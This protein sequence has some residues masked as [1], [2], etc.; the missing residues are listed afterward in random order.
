MVAG[1]GGV[2]GPCRQRDASETPVAKT[3]EHLAGGRDGED[4]GAGPAVLE[5][6]PH[7]AAG[8]YGELLLA[9]VDDRRG[10]E[11]GR[12]R[13]VVNAAGLTEVGGER[14]RQRAWRGQ[15]RSEEV[16]GVG[17]E[18]PRSGPLEGDQ[19]QE[20]LGGDPAG[21][22]RELGPSVGGDQGGLPEASGI[23]AGVEGH[24]V[25]PSVEGEG[26]RAGRAGDHGT[27]ILM[28][29]VHGLAW[30]SGGPFNAGQRRGAGHDDRPHG[31]L[32]LLRSIRLAFRL[33]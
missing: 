32:L 33:V 20:L 9:E 13:Q 8:R 2:V 3:D 25:T 26:E 19:V 23:T 7:P 17:D 21:A 22:G 28:S 24:L 29:W 31:S 5:D 1:P 4:G 18:Q 6:L 11:T 30:P 27:G 12:I 10:I 14:D 16:G 15:Q